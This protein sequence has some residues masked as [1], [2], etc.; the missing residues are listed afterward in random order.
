MDLNIKLTI[1]NVKN[2]KSFDYEFNFRKG[3][4]ALVG[5]NAVGKST[6][7]SAIAST[8]YPKTLINLSN[9]EVNENSRIVVECKGKTD[10]W[11][12]NSKLN[13]M[14]SNRSNVVF[15]GIYEGSIFSG[16]RFEDMKNIDKI[17]QDNQDFVS[18]FVSASEELKYALSIILHNEDNYYNELYKLK[19]FDIAKKYELNNMPYFLKLENGQYISKYKMSSGECMLISLLNFINSTAL[20]PEFLKFRKQVIDNR[21]FV[22]IDEVELALHPS[23][24]IRLIDY[25]EDMIKTK[26]LTVLFSTHSSELIKRINPENIYYLDNHGGF[27]EL[28]SPCYPHYAIRSL[29]DHDGYDST[30]L[31]EDRLTEII[32][33]RLVEDFRVKNNLLINVLPVGS[34]NN[35]LSFQARAITQNAF[36]RDKFLFSVIDGDV[37]EQVN[38]CEQYSN[39]KKL[40]LPIKSVEKYLYN[41]LIINKD[42][43]FIKIIGNKYFTLQPLDTIVK[44]FCMNGEGSKDDSGKSLFKHLLFCLSKVGYN[45]TDFVKSLCDDLFEYENFNKLKENIEKFI[46]GNYYICNRY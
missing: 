41:K 34:W 23:S 33:K 28:I 21:L 17:I 5:E 27:A 35:T 13:R 1:E 24:I 3:I 30:I 43:E 42:T 46:I 11:L 15:N 8:V 12:F 7:M 39:L 25:L 38:K 10:T 26:D 6:V 36:G 14:K 20:K 19:K 29:Y 31:V 2:I 16:T 40:F 45:E 4:Y 37:K 9:T 32:I 22:F 18:E 44:N